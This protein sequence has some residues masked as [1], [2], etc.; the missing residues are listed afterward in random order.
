MKFL[1]GLTLTALIYFIIKLITIFEM[2][3]SKEF[4]TGAV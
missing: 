2:A 4:D 1:S 3:K